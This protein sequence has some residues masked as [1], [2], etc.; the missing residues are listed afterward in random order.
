MSDRDDARLVRL[1]D[2]VIDVIR[3]SRGGTP[4]SPY[5]DSERPSKLSEEHWTCPGCSSCATVIEWSCGCRTVRWHYKYEP[6]DPDRCEPLAGSH[7]GPYYP[8]CRAL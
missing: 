7:T 5:S 8:D 4:G 3:V 1:I 6:S 2:T